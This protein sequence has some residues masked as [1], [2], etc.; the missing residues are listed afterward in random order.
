M[1]IQESDHEVQ[2]MFPYGDDLLNQKMKFYELKKLKKVT[3][4]PERESLSVTKLNRL[5]L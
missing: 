2:L 3:I 4:F 1:A 5:Q